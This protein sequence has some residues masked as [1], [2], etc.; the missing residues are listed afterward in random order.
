MGIL[1]YITSQLLLF[2]LRTSMDEGC[3][4]VW[5]VSSKSNR[6]ILEEQQ[7]YNVNNWDKWKHSPAILLITGDQIV[8]KKFK[9][10]NDASIQ[11]IT[12]N[13]DLI[14]NSYLHIDSE[15]QTLSFL[16]KDFT[17]E[18]TGLFEKNNIYVLEKWINK[19]ENLNK[20]QMLLDFCH[21][22]IKI[23]DLRNNP[24][25]ANKFSLVAYYKLRLPLLLFFF[26]I[27]LGNFLLNSRIRQEYEAV[28][29]ELYLNQRKNKQQLDNQKKQGRIQL[30][31]ES[32][33]KRSLALIADRIASYV[34]PQI[35][36]N[37][38]VISPLEGTGKNFISRNKELKFNNNL[39]TVKG[40]T[41]IPGGISLFTQYLDS[42]NLFSN[43]KIHSLV[44]EK[45][46]SLFTFELNVELKP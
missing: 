25:Q 45:D 15:E 6:V 13:P 38:L 29:S 8:E 44:K 9:S 21:K 14:W 27:L 30:Q 35:I 46:S 34:P 17:E 23:S 28:K 41:E 36:L 40:E 37:S 42:D 32:I 1:K 18:L 12:D 43:V 10:T 3:I 5:K 22:K 7:Y 16:R 4:R 20:E 19:K 31:F 2:E 39:I 26:I 33:P 11:K 24:I